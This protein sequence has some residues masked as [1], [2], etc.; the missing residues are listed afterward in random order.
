MLRG[1]IIGGTY[2]VQR[3]LGEGAMGLVVAARHRMTGAHVAIKLLKSDTS[4]TTHTRRFL[5]EVR[6]ASQLRNDHVARVLDW[7]QLFDGRPYMVMELLDGPDLDTM[8]ADAPIPAR[9]AATYIMQACRG[10]AEAHAL[11]MIHRDIKPANLMLSRDRDGQPIIKVVDFGIATASYSDTDDEITAVHTVLGSVSYM[12]PEQLRSSSEID[13]RSDVWSLGVTLYQ[14]I[15]GRFPFEGDTFAS[16]AVSVTT[17][18]HDPLHEAEPALA[19]VIDRCLEKDP[20]DRFASVD[21]LAAALAPFTIANHAAMTIRMELPAHSTS[22]MLAAELMR[23]PRLPRATWLAAAAVV[24]A[25]FGAALVGRHARIAASA[26]PTS[27]P[28]APIASPIITPPPP[29]SPVR[30]PTITKLTAEPIFEPAVIELEP[31][32]APVKRKP[33]RLRAKRFAKIEPTVKP[34][35]EPKPARKVRTAKCSARDPHCL[36]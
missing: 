22:Q 18:P 26:S 36:L 19:A 6:G 11:G 23:R 3:I 17:D 1:E 2:E 34:I 33:S 31:E 27:V 15:S 16:V 9:L 24:L 30:Q 32:P 10:L 29:P 35:E 5:R 13:P 20:D 8:L 21:A 7:G 25:I 12:S 28:M 14:L 4:N